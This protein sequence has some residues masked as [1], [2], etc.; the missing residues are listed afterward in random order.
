MIDE[1]LKR[2]ISLMK[3]K[4][5]QDQEMIEYLGLPRG[6][7][8]NWKREKGK[9]Y[10]EYIDRIADRLD[11]TIDYLFRGKTTDTTVLTSNEKD[12][13]ENYRKLSSEKQAILFELSKVMLL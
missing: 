1:T 8:S 11:V 2:I 5:I 13:F 7:F 3:E 12:F 10:Y 9:S 4:K 6:A